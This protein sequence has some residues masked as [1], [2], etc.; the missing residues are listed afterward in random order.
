MIDDEWNSELFLRL[1]N[2]SLFYQA[3]VS[4]DVQLGFNFV[5]YRFFIAAQCGQSDEF[6][7]SGI[8]SNQYI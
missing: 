8:Y 5:L 1:T 2:P 6:V 7:F 3:A 4:W